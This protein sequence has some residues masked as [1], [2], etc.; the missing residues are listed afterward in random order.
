MTVFFESIL[1]FLFTSPIVALFAVPI[2]FYSI[3]LLY[4]A[5]A[6]KERI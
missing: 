6:Q 4:R 5:F 2:P 3:A 1:A